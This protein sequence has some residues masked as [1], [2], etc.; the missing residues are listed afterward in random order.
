MSVLSYQIGYFAG[1]LCREALKS[2][3][4]REMDNPPDYDLLSSLPSITR[5]GINLF[6]WHDSNVKPWTPRLIVP[7]KPSGID[8]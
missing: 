3:R 6:E 5:R 8:D 4:Q 7:T 1:T 2:L